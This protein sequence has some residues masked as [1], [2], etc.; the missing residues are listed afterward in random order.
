VK[1]QPKSAKPKHKWGSAAKKRMNTSAATQF[2]VAAMYLSGAKQRKISRELGIDRETVSRILGQEEAELLV[3]GYR[4]ALLKIVPNALIAAS[5]LVQR[6]NPKIVT[7]VLRGAR[8]MVD[9]HEV[10]NIPPPVQDYSYSRIL[11]FGK[12]KRWPTDEEAIK[13]DKTIPVKP[14][15]KGSLEE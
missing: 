14:T 15:V 5:E 10:A 2:N 11:F 7:D 4:E 9:R 12:Y 1:N 6:L 13:F 8:V 3:H